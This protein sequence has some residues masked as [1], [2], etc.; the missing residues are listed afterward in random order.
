MDVTLE[1]L[2]TSAEGAT[3][4]SPANLSGKRTEGK[5]ASAGCFPRPGGRIIRY[6]RTVEKPPRSVLSRKKERV[7]YA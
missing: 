7:G 3:R 1:K 6:F 5:T 2:D 4:V